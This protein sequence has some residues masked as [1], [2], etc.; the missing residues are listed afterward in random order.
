M[1]LNFSEHVVANTQWRLF[2]ANLMPHSYNVPAWSLGTEHAGRNVIILPGLSMLPAKTRSQPKSTPHKSTCVKISSHRQWL[3]KAH[4]SYVYKQLTIRCHKPWLFKQTT[5]PTFLTNNLYFPGLL[6]RQGTPRRIMKNVWVKQLSFHLYNKHTWKKL[7]MCA[8]FAGNPNGKDG[9][10]CPDVCVV[11]VKQ[12][13][14]TPGHVGIGGVQTNFVRSGVQQW[15]FVNTSEYTKE[16]RSSLFLTQLQ[17]IHNLL[18]LKASV[19]VSPAFS[20]A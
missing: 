11:I 6:D 17:S 5:Q 10:V 12:C 20:P 14:H 15:M 8:D 7:D 3:N 2:K 19:H 16:T 9:P 1:L 4:H 18:P 13:C